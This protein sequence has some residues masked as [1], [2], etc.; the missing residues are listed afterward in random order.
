[1]APSQT[2]IVFCSSPHLT[3]IC[4]LEQAIERVTAQITQ[5]F[6]PPT[7][8]EEA[9]SSQKEQE[10]TPEMRADSVSQKEQDMTPEMRADSASQQES[11][12]SAQAALS[13]SEAVVLLC[14]IPGIGE[15]AA[16]GILAE[17]GTNMEQFP[18]AAHLASWAAV[19]PGNNES[20]G[21]RKSGKTRKGNPWLRCLLVQA[22]HSASHQ[23]HCY[24]AEQYRRI[25]KRRGSK[26][27]AVAVAHSILVIIYH[28]LR[29]HTT[30]QE[31]GETFFEEQERQGAE[32]RLLR[33]LARLGYRAELLPV[34]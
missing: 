15:R 19:C 22:A 17:I 13:F 29:N 9:T 32:K 21:K 20:A 8:A 10:V 24:L 30:Y 28:L 27:A 16:I 11:A 18:T 26:R 7:P 5:R 33:Q 14:S 25:A 31:R 6:T 3:Q 2:I 1:M 34:A 12:S 4:H 23:K